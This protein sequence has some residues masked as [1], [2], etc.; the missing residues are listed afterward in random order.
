MLAALAALLGCAAAPVI[1]DLAFVGT[2]TDTPPAGVRAAL[3]GHVARFGAG[4]YAVA[5]SRYAVPDPTLG[6]QPLLSRVATDPAVQRGAKRL[7][8]PSD[9]P[10]RY[11][12]ELWRT[13]G[14]DGIAVAL[15]TPSGSPDGTRLIGYYAITFA[16]GFTPEMR[17]P[18]KPG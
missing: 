9:Q 10:E 18:A 13:R 6:W 8:M 14:R 12:I 1:G 5:G 2:E 17:D 15:L 11:L 16:A 4:R 7:V 3:D